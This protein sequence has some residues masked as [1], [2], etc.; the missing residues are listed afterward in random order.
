MTL[1]EL[2]IA[3]I[4]ALI[5][6][7]CL[8]SLLVAITK[9]LGSVAGSTFLIMIT[10]ISFLFFQLLDLPDRVM[11]VAAPALV[12]LIVYLIALAGK[13]KKEE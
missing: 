7:I 3:I 13:N 11:L 2:I 10:F 4:V 6:T 9:K 1:G 12:L 8:A 5:I